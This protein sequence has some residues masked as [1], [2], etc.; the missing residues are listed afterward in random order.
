MAMA[1]SW[2]GWMSDSSRSRAAAREGGVVISVSDMRPATLG[3]HG[4]I[5]HGPPVESGPPADRRP[6]ASGDVP[7]FAGAAIW[8]WAPIVGAMDIVIAGGHGKIALRL[9]H[10]LSQQGH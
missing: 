5:A 4:R 10:L 8:A 9:E 1:S 3:R 7:V 6:V 2:R